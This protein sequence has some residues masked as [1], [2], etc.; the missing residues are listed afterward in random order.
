MSKT[1]APS[2]KVTHRGK[3]GRKFMSIVEAQ[4]DKAELF[5]DEAQRV[6]DTPGL[7]DIIAS[8]IAENRLTDK[9]KDEEVKSN[10][11]YPSGYK[12]KDLVPQSNDLRGL[13]G[14]VGFFDQ[15]YLTL[16]QSGKI[17]L[18]DGAEG[19]FAIPQ[20]QKIAPTYNEAVEKVL[21][22]IAS[23]R[24]FYNWREGQLGPDRLRQHPRTA[25]AL[26]VIAEQQKNADILIV[27]AQF[28]K[29][30]AGRSVRRARE[31]FTSP[32]FGLD[33][34]TNAVMLLTHPERLTRFEDL[35]IDCAGDE[36]APGADGAFGRA[37]VF[38]FGDGRVKFGAHWV[39]D[40]SGYCGS[41][42]GFVPQS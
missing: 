6:N 41:A 27:P 5:E 13:I 34:F 36:Y 35:W 32:E 25:H 12:V 23:K 18:P 28:G 42:S 16:V 8:F 38:R 26:D 40:A 2:Q 33:A 37:P 10:Y 7:G 21:A 22:L 29:R 39:G 20:W 17:A 14:G 19:W 11:S 4:Y 1:L 31:V 9:F 30:H 15:D 24:K 3:K